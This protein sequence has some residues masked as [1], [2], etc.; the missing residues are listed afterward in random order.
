M[1]ITYDLVASGGFYLLAV[2][3]YTK[4]AWLSVPML[5]AIYAK[6]ADA[7]MHEFIVSGGKMKADSEI[8]IGGNAETLAGALYRII[9]GID[10]NQLEQAKLAANRLYLT[11]LDQIHAKEHVVD[12]DPEVV[13]KGSKE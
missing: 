7:F 6:V 5:N 1:E 3:I 10:T 8:G 9:K 11:I 4:Y 13:K 2:N 12:S